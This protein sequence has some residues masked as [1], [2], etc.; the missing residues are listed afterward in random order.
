LRHSKGRIFDFLTDFQAKKRS[1][2]W[3]RVQIAQV[4]STPA[5]D[6]L[7]NSLGISWDYCRHTKKAIFAFLTDFQAKKAK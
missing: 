3:P 7:G 1:E 6:G 2:G 4:I 5:S